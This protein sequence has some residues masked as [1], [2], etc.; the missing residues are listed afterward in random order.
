MIDSMT[1]GDLLPPDE[2]TMDEAN[3]QPEE[4]GTAR[5]QQ[6]SNGPS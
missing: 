6:S 5:A 4:S 3:T 1:I 2:A